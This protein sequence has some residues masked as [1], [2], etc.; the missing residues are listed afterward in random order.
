M[1]NFL[2]FET[3]YYQVFLNEDDQYYLG[4]SVVLLKRRAKTLSEV[5]PEEWIDLGLVVRI[6]ERALKKAFNATNFNWS[7]TLNTAYQNNPPDPQVYWHVRPRYRKQFTFNG[8]IFRDNLFGR[9]YQAK[10]KFLLSPQFHLR[11]AEEIRK[12]L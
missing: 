10:T 4:R 7:C 6:Y 2:L 3:E 8:Q 11:I 9:H 1:N 5:T 12:Y